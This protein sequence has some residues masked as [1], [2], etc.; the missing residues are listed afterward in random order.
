MSRIENFILE[1]NDLIKSIKEKI[2]EYNR[3]GKEYFGDQWCS[4]TTASDI[5]VFIDVTKLEKFTPDEVPFN[6][7]GISYDL[8]YNFTSDN[9]KCDFYEGQCMG[10]K[11]IETIPIELSPKTGER[12]YL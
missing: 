7:N 8:G 5:R 1:N 12:T 2:A 11:V 9:N 4:V 3:R 10:V 6:T